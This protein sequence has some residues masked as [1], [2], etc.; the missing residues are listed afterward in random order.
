MSDN[1]FSETVNSLFKGMDGFLSTKTVVGEPMHVDDTIIIPLADVS[2][3]VG[4]G[5]FAQEKND[6]GGGGLGGKIQPSAMLVIKDGTTKL[7]SIRS[8]S[9]VNKV[10]DMVPDLINKFTGKKG[11]AK[12]SVDG[13]D[14]AEEAVNPEEVVVETVTQEA[15]APEETDQ[16]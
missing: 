16:K 2:F 6:N 10:I 1:K 3:G 7:I 9:P 12:V 5:V 8:S 15:A 4:A 11:G 14:S 13:A